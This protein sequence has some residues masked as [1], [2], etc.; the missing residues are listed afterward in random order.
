MWMYHHYAAGEETFVHSTA[1]C[2]HTTMRAG[3][4]AIDGTL[5]AR[6]YAAIGHLLDLPPAL[7]NKKKKR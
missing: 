4:K 1:F 7:Q 5:W 2:R 3:N 6:M